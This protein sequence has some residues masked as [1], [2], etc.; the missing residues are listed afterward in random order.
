MTVLML[1]KGHL[2]M[3]RTVIFQL[4]ASDRNLMKLG[5]E[6]H[7][8]I[9]LRKKILSVTYGCTHRKIWKA[10]HRIVYR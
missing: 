3:V 7:D 6:K 10:I 9:L 1:L 8:L 2:K 4:R 5:K